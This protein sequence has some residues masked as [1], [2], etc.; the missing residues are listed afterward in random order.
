MTPSDAA[1]LLDASYACAGGI[2]STTASILIAVA[3]TTYPVGYLTTMP[4]WTSDARGFPRY[5]EPLFMSSHIVAPLRL[6]PLAGMKDA[7]K[8]VRSR[9]VHLIFLSDSL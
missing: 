1:C 5:D 6:T 3:N 9:P 4:S 2:A 8:G 7:N